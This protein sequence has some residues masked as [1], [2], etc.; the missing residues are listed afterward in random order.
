[1]VQKHFN[2]NTDK[3]LPSEN[4]QQVPNDL[5]ND[6][7]NGRLTPLDLAVYM[8]LAQHLG[9]NA[10]C[11]PGNG[12]I[13]KTIGRE[14]QAVSDS[15]TRLSRAGYIARPTYNKFG[16]KN[17]F[18]L[19]RVEGGKIVRTKMPTNVEARIWQPDLPPLPS[20]T[21]SA[22]HD[23]EISQAEL[24]ELLASAPRE[25]QEEFTPYMVAEL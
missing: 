10:C 12:T 13:A 5:V 25:E 3:G 23:V 11:W 21:L 20:V 1:M 15:M 18:L 9:E 24:A 8:V 19:V 22:Q 4:Y 6:I 14:R 16:T 17:T 7:R 2:R